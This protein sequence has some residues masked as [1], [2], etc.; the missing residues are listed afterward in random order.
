MINNYEINNHKFSIEL[1]NGNKIK[2]HID[3]PINNIYESITHISD[4]NSP[5]G[6][7]DTYSII[8]EC[9]K[10]SSPNYHFTTAFKDDIY[11]LK[12]QSEFLNY[13]FTFLIKVERKEVD[14]TLHKFIKLND[15]LKETKIKNETEIS[16]LKDIKIK[17]ETEISDLKDII[18]NIDFVDIKF[19]KISL[20]KSITYLYVPILSVEVVLYSINDSYKIKSLYKLE[21]LTLSS[22]F[23]SLDF[24]NKNL[25]T[26]ILIAPNLETLN[27][28][29]KFPNLEVLELSTCDMLY[30]IKTYLTNTTIKKIIFRRCG[31]NQKRNMIS[32]CNA[33][34]IELSFC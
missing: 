29:N 10:K 12:F 6:Y 2:I 23:K 20:S 11:Y 3:N 1:I 14:L 26:L 34:N 32:Y 21:K 30:D 13:Q 28:I 18:N 19:S 7:Q 9:I 5:F 16:D 4:L 15:L 31:G 25:K 17:N 24:E 22:D 8:L 27:G 33:K